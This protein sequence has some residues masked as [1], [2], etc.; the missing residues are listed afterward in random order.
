[1]ASYIIVSRLAVVFRASNIFEI[2]VSIY[3]TCHS[4]IWWKYSFKYIIMPYRSSRRGPSRA[5]VSSESLEHHRKDHEESYSSGEDARCRTH[6]HSYHNRPRSSERLGT[7]DQVPFLPSYVCCLTLVFAEL[8]RCDEYRAAKSHKTSSRRPPLYRRNAVQRYDRKGR[9]YYEVDEASRRRNSTPD[10]SEM[11]RFRS[12]SH[13]RSNSYSDRHRNRNRRL[14]SEDEDEEYGTETEEPRS[15]R[16]PSGYSRSSSRSSARRSM[17]HHGRRPSTP[18]GH[19]NADVYNTHATYQARR[20]SD[21]QPLPEISL[22]GARTQKGHRPLSTPHSPAR[23]I[24]YPGF[25]SQDRRPESQHALIKWN[26]PSAPGSSDCDSID[27]YSVY[28]GDYACGP[29]GDEDGNARFTEHHTSPRPKHTLRQSNT[30]WA[31]AT[32]VRICTL[33]MEW[34]LERMHEV[35]H[36]SVEQRRRARSM[37]GRIESVIQCARFIDQSP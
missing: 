5:H 6:Q 19:R 18:H 4:L 17:H 24:E 15:T 25:D 31:K 35:Q 8:K 23:L 12:H 30:A 13:S 10:R 28:D 34:K 36:M 3:C 37:W 14:P 1:M 20:D 9:D 21:S 11:N 33:A 27:E 16:Y 2:V 22:P 32:T 7:Q 26:N 29:E